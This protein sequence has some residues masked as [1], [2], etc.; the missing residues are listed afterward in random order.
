MSQDY[1]IVLHQFKLLSSYLALDSLTDV[2]FLQFT[3]TFAF[4]FMDD[5]LTLHDPH[6]LRQPKV[7]KRFF[8]R[9][10]IYIVLD[11]FL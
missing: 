2:C 6:F 4:A 8:Q 1:I 11:H 7:E 10:V 3:R 9:F 5:P